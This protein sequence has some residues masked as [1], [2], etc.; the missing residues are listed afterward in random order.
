MSATQI[1]PAKAFGRR[2]AQERRHKAVAEERDIAQKDVAKALSVSESTV[3]RW[4]AGEVM[5]RDDVL[6]RLAKYFGVTPAWLRYGQEPRAAPEQAGVDTVAHDPRKKA[7]TKRSG[8][9]S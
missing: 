3:S 9:A 7:V 8:R 1:T 6:T 4:E 5:P 2:V